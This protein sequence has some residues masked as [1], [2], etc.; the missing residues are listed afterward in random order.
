MSALSFSDKQI[1]ESGLCI[2]YFETVGV[3][4][5]AYYAYLSMKPADIP[6]FDAARKRGKF[7]LQDHGKI[8][9]AGKG[10][11]NNQ[12]K[13]FLKDEY[14]FDAEQTAILYQKAE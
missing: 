2:F 4:G 10:K 11:P 12:V 13:Q 7:K 8:L 6:K 5:E 1:L 9:A 3:D 14:G